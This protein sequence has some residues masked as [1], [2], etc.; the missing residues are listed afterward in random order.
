MVKIH[1]FTYAMFDTA[2]ISQGDL[3]LVPDSHRAE[4]RKWFAQDE[5]RTMYDPAGDTAV[6]EAYFLYV[7]EGA[8]PEVYRLYLGSGSVHLEDGLAARA[9]EL[10][11]NL[12]TE[13]EETR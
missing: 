4:Y 10:L 9:A 12:K 6:A 5:G 2:R 13:K 7:P 11:L 1:P 3:Y 8:S